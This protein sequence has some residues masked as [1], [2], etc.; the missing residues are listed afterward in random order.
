[1]AERGFSLPAKPPQAPGLPQN[2]IPVE[3]GQFLGVNTRAARPAIKEEEMYWCDGFIPIG[4]NNLRTLWGVGP[5]LYT[6]TGGKTVS[7]FSF[8]NI[9]ATTYGLVFLSDGS[10]VA[11]NTSTLV[12][13]TIAPAATISNPGL[14]LIGVS[15]FGSTIIAICAKQTN[16]YFV[17]DGT[18]FFKASTL[19]PNILILNGGAL[20]TSTPTIA[21]YGGAGSGAT[22]SSTVSNGLVASV[23]VTNPGTGYTL[24]DVAALTFTGG[25]SNTS[26]RFTAVLTS[27]VITSVTVNAGGTGYT[28]SGVALSVFGGGGG[29]AKLTATVGAGAI[30]AVTVVSGGLGYLTTPTVVASDPNNAVA[31]ALAPIMPFGISG[32][33]L[34]TYASRVWIA[35]G[36][37]VVFSAPASAVDFSTQNGAGAFSSTDSFLRQS[38]QRLIQ[39]NGFL[40]LLGDSSI[41][42]ISGVSTTSTTNATTGVTTVVTSFSN[43]NV[44][45]QVGA[46][47]PLSAK[48]FGRRIMFGNNFGIH[49][50]F[51]GSVEKVSTPLDGVYATVPNFAGFSASSAVAQIFGLQIFMTLLP[52]I[53]P[54]SG[55]QVNKLLMWNGQ[56][57]FSS[58][59]EITLTQVET[60]EIN[61][62]LT[63]YGTD[64][65]VIRPMFQT[66]STTLNKVVQSKLWP[67]PGYWC[68]K[69]ARRLY[70]MVDY[71][72][73]QNSLLNMS[74][75]S[76][77]VGN[78]V[79]VTVPSS[80]LVWS[81]N[82]GNPI[83]WTNASSATIIWEMAGINVFGPYAVS[84]SGPLMGLTLQTQ[85]ADLILLSLTL[86][87]ENFTA[88]V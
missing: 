38:W 71:V 78:S 21:A 15:Q 70:G 14:G 68:T 77:I 5:V 23:T 32:T 56:H 59:Q 82:A 81:N 66:P 72:N 11:V 44:D 28:T 9:G 19:G 79:N 4:P 60:L 53:D 22:F 17:W 10:I 48:V 76:N 42:Y 65:T 6:A 3:F 84:T 36:S 25:G 27:G 57:W 80:Q 31:V 47:W 2:L 34:E 51:G 58:T 64:G 26:A 30:T 43:L 74:V 37:T 16:G 63:A 35:N 7:Y 67:D 52:I 54:I 12:A 33:T 50:C 49:V 62:Q 39:T 87:A 73:A 29:G 69:M 61:S 24:A 41:N 88:N 85:A 46:T 1:M 55:Q 83:T 40:Y 45:P 20:Y 13:S 86:L 18:N 8:G 75:D